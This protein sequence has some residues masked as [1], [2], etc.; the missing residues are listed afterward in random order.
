LAAF[1]IG[2]EEFKNCV[3]PETVKWAK[4][5]KQAGILKFTD[6]VAAQP[7]DPAVRPNR[8]ND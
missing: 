1:V 3:E 4:V 7:A 5:V 8:D 2:G 6:A